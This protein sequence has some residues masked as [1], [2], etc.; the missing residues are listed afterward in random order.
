MSEYQIYAIRYARKDDRRSS[1]NFVG[2]DAADTPMPLDFF[3]WA[4]VGRERTVIVDTGFDEKAGMPRGY[5]ISRPVAEGL[6]QIDIDPAGVKDVILTHMHWDHAGNHEL[7]PQARYHVQEREMHFCTGRCMCD[8][9]QKKAYN[10]ED[11]SHIVKR[12]FEGRVVLHDT[13]ADFDE[14]I[15]LH[16]MGGHTEGLQVVRVRTRR[17]YVVLASDA[18]HYY[19]NILQ[20][21]PFPVLFDVDQMLNGFAVIQKLADSPSH[22][23]PGHDRQVLSL[24]PAARD[25]LDG[26]AR[27][28][29]AP[30][31]SPA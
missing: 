2:G 11:V 7:F 8:P 1:E 13:N 4:L 29:V 22:I 31:G 19:A 27:L 10:S 9:V 3:V 21:R 5:A 20:R 15:S 26:I 23:I 6:K 14:G 18:S 28:D 17:G 24:F 25:G 30:H 12:H 16:W